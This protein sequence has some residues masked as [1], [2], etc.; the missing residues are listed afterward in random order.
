MTRPRFFSPTNL[1]DEFTQLR[2]LLA[3]YA[4]EK[5]DVVLSSGKKSNF[6]ID[7][8]RVSLR[9]EGHRLIGTL[10]ANAA[11]AL[12]PDV[13]AVGG[14]TLGADPLASATSLAS[15]SNQNPLDAFI[16]RK[17]PKKHGTS[18]WIEGADHLSKGAKVVVVEDVV[19][20]GRST[21]LAI[22]RIT[23]AGLKVE[24]VLALVD[25]QEGG[26]EAVIEH[27]PLTS[28]FKKAD[29]Q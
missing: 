9:A 28:L 12:C 29:F 4:Y 5:R 13:V 2:S 25:R 3:K 17:E 19:T 10:F 22:E 8:K 16:V 18:L 6:Y 20:T 11:S 27:A 15:L 24:Q 14:M 21:L 26:Y 23:A 7:C 1:T